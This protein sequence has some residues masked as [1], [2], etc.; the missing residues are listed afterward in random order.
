MIHLSLHF[1]KTTTYTDIPMIIL[2]VDVPMA[3]DRLVYNIVMIENYGG[4]DGVI[5]ISTG[6]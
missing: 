4:G 5:A 1:K 6:S 3:V 2:L